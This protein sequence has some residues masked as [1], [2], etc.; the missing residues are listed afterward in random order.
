MNR[1]ADRHSPWYKLYKLER[2]R[3][4]SIFR[5]LLAY[6]KAHNVGSMF[7]HTKSVREL[8]K[9]GYK[10]CGVCGHYVL[11]EFHFPHYK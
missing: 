6:R 5:I 2:S 4:T 1:N 7:T 8:H 11:K 10:Y 3:K 9:L